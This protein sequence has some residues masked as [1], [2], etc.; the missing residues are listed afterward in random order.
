MRAVNDDDDVNF[1]NCH[2]CNK[3]EKWN[4]KWEHPKA[5]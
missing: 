5:T 1:Y 3:R 2:E 4:E